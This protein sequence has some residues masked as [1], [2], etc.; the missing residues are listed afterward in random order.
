MTRYAVL[1]LAALVA[2][3]G[4]AAPR[5]P[6]RAAAPAADPV[7]YL[8]GTLAPWPAPDAHGRLAVTD[9]SRGR[10]AAYDSALVV[11]VLIR[12][13]KRAEAASVLEGLHALQGPD[14][15]LP[16]SFV[17]PRPDPIAY[18]RSGAVAWAGYAAAEYLDA[19]AGGPGRAEALALA[20]G[21]ASYVMGRQVAKPGDPRDGL[22]RGGAGVFR[23]ELDD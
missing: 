21:A 2:C 23:Y 7:A 19:E 10:V 3:S 13:G 16:F 1:A 5:Q 8:R 12:A 4:A 20:R 22:V 17:L 15:A 18:V 11:L 14:G 6:A 9:R